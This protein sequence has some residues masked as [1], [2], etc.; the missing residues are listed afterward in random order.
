MIIILLHDFAWI[1][2]VDVSFICS[3]LCTGAR[4]NF[5]SVTLFLRLDRQTAR[6]IQTITVGNQMLGYKQDSPGLRTMQCEKA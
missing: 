5:K 6:F 1:R 2:K 4:S 3:I